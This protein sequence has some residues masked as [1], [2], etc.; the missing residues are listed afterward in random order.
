RSDANTSKISCT[1]VTRKLYRIIGVVIAVKASV[2]S[3]EHTIINT[4]G[5]NTTNVQFRNFYGNFQSRWTS[6]LNN[7]FSRSN[8][9]P[10]TTAPPMMQCLL[11]CK[12]VSNNKSVIGSERKYWSPLMLAHSCCRSF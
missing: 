11:S 8:D 12:Y 9:A 2:G 6:V 10:T 5:R 3:H 7:L 1:V 4:F